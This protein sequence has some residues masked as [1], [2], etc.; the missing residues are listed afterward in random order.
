M[1]DPCDPM[2]PLVRAFWQVL[3]NSPA[4]RAW[5]KRHGHALIEALQPPAGDD[6]A[7]LAEI[8]RLMREG[9]QG[10]DGWGTAIW[11]HDL[12]AR[13]SDVA[14]LGPMEQRRLE[15]VE[16]WEAASA[17]VSQSRDLEQAKERALEVTE[18][19]QEV[20]RLAVEFELVAMD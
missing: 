12:V 9:L 13:V 11:D 19:I 20:I 10:P 15:L 8:L 4:E 16:S 18:R 7:G 14:A 6:E 17:H 2:P 3:S 5:L 1:T